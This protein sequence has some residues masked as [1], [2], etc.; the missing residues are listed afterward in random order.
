MR[1]LRRQKKKRTGIG[2]GGK[3]VRLRKPPAILEAIEEVV[4]HPPLPRPPPRQPSRRQEEEEEEEEE[5]EDEEMDT[6]DEDDDRDMSP[7]EDDDDDPPTGATP[8]IDQ[9]RPE[10]TEMRVSEFTGRKRTR[11]GGGA[12]GVKKQFRQAPVSEALVPV[13]SKNLRRRMAE[14]TR[15]KERVSRQR[16]RQTEGDIAGALMGLFRENVRKAEENRILD[17]M[18]KQRFRRKRVDEPLR[19]VGRK[20]KKPKAVEAL[21]APPVRPALPAP[22]APPKKQKRRKRALIE[23]EAVE[24]KTGV[25]NVDEELRRIAE[26][27][28]GSKRMRREGKSAPS[29]TVSDFEHDFKR[30]RT[31]R[32]GEDVLYEF[33]DTMEKKPPSKD[34]KV[35]AF[36]ENLKAVNKHTL[37][38]DEMARGVDLAIRLFGE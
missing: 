7:R 36:V 38:F 20:P 27:E 5:D 3:R 29:R 8:Y 12:G 28:F 13:G 18:K 2:G 25:S 10:N 16:E 11:R 15:R 19:R 33:I 17:E 22:G 30:A 37:D 24:G 9:T 4:R 26:R 35:R 34:P 32:E 14:K 23:E 1:R 31:E 6:E 21:P